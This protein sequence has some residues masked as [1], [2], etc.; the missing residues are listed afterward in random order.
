MHPRDLFDFMREPSVNRV[1]PLAQLMRGR[2][3]QFYDS[4]T[5]C[6][7]W[8]TFASVLSYAV[9]K[10]F[11]WFVYFGVPALALC[12]AYSHLRGENI[13]AAAT[14]GLLVAGLSWLYV[15]LNDL[16]YSVQVVVELYRQGQPAAK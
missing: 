13:K 2:R 5:P 4:S 3:H 16:F 11:S 10:V 14:V 1:A 15:A 9:L 6:P 7:R 8:R 12:T